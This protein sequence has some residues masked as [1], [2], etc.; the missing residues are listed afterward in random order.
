MKLYITLFFCVV[1]GLIYAQKQDSTAVFKKKVLE[2]TE[3]DF[4]S[5]YYNQNGQHAAVSGGIG[6]EKLKDYASNIVVATPLND[7]DVLTFDVGI[8]AYTSA[9]S[10]N[11]NPFNSILSS[12][13]ASGQTTQVNNTKPT[14]TPW[15]AS[16]GAS[17]R[18]ALLAVNT[19]YSHSS[20]DRNFIWN[21]DVALSTEF[22]YNSRGLGGG[23]TK[24]FNHKNTEVSFKAN[25]YFDNWKII[26]PTELNEYNTYGNSFLTS[27]HFQGVTVLN[28]NG[29]GSTL[30]RPT[31]FKPWESSARN[32]FSGSF[33]FSQ[34]LTKRM[35]VSLFFDILQQQGMLSTPY[36][37]IYFADKANYYIGDKQ[38]IPIYQSPDNKG[39]Y[40]LADDIERL[41]GK[42]FK[43]P[44]GLRW[45]YFINEKFVL[46][47]YYRYYQDDWDI[48]AHTFS[49]ELPVKL[50]D[51]FTVY[52][53]YR[54]YVQTQSKY[55]APYEQHLST[56][57][58][59]TSDYDLSAFVANQYGVGATYTDL[60]TQFSIFGLKVKN[61]DFR[62]N[63]YARSDG[64]NANIA[65]ISFKFITY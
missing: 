50:S 11:V 35:Q 61:I 14:G 33:S 31:T 16:S 13:G 46:R 26:Y 41:P 9:S 32:S 44:V 22:N 56:E 30:Y 58:Y 10:S 3:V 49:V 18:G 12:T 45:N 19:S 55:F 65:T 43:L 17:G 62:F 52:P 7:D 42:R 47:T 38:Y 53:M 4:V 36:Q 59:Y 34:V 27:G 51:A 15:Q 23:V 6:T 37:R 60:L 1:S 29:V 57:Q 25:A 2:G 24:L 63:H 8:S 48:K 54:Y 21:A 5:S 39:V 64:L 28:Q 40:Q 20:N